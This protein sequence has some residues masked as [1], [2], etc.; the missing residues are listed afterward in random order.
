[1]MDLPMT[2]PKRSVSRLPFCLAPTLSPLHLAAWHLPN[3]LPFAGMLITHSL[4]CSSVTATPQYGGTP[5]HVAAKK[6]QFETAWLLL[7]CGAEVDAKDRVSRNG[8]LH[9]WS[10]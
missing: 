7:R 2:V 3:G 5:L 9:S 4:A 1:M 6:G 8:W 10:R